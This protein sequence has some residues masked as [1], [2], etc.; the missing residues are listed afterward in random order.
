MR[1]DVDAQRELHLVLALARRE[2]QA[3]PVLAR[4]VQM[5]DLG[6]EAQMRPQ[7]ASGRSGDRPAVFRIAVV[8]DA[9]VATR[10]EGIKPG[11]DRPFVQSERGQQ[12]GRAEARIGPDPAAA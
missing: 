4:A 9:A 12:E 5:Q 3:K 6:E 10:A 7:L 11:R 8:E 1:S 2:T